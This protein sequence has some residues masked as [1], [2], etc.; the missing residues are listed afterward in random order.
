M[1]GQAPK[2]RRSGP[3]YTPEQRR[4]RDGTFWTLVQAILAP[5]QFAVFAVSLVLVLRYLATGEGLWWA[6]LSILVKT[7]CLYLIMVTGAIW[8]KVVFGQYLLAPAFFWEDVFSFGVIALHTAYL[9]A[10][11]S[12]MSPEV[13][14]WIALA[15]YGAYVINA[16]QFLLKLRMARLEGAPA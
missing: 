13:Q 12:G 15:A 16:V 5:V 11:F 2:I 10:F 8:E 9:W 14:M 3:L 4:R 1:V 7:G 6:T